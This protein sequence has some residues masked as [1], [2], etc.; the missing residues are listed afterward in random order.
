LLVR[1]GLDAPPFVEDVAPTSFRTRAI[2]LAIAQ[3]CNLG[4]T[5]C[6]AEGGSFG[7]IQK[8]MPD[9][10]AIDAVSRLID[11]ARPGD[12]VNVAFLGGEPLTNRTALIA[13]TKFAIARAA[14]R[15]VQASFSI[16]TNGTLVTPDDGAFFER[17]GFAVTV[18][19]DGIGED[20]DRLRPFKGGRGSFARIAERIRPLLA[21]QRRMQVSA[22]VTVTP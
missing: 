20:H 21:M 18:S 22:R 4:C 3:K 2:S 1:L 5:Y 19:I 9:R 12:R 14:D 17:H 13:T 10:V 11:E 6:Y 8:N 16:T 7:G 15:G